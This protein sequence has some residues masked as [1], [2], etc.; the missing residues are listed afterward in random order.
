MLFFFFKKVWL[1]FLF[2][3]GVFKELMFL[4]WESVMFRVRGIGVVDMFKKC[5]FL[6]NFFKVF[7][8]FML[9]LCSLF[10]IIKFRFLNF[11]F[12][13]VCVFISVLICFNFIVFKSLFFLF[14]YLFKWVILMLKFL[15]CVFK[16]LKCWCVN[17]VV[18]IIKAFWKLFKNA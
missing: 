9:N 15:K 5:M 2:V 13:I 11:A 4:I 18:G 1:G 3:G 14:V 16:V 17:K 6:F 10:I 8:C 12:K 7:F